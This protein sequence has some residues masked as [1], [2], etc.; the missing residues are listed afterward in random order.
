MCVIT[1]TGAMVV[2]G[3]ARTADRIRSRLDIA[4][5]CFPTAVHPALTPARGFDLERSW[6]EEAL[7]PCAASRA[8]RIALSRSIGRWSGRLV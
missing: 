7:S 4:E 3:S 5:T 2:A 6:T 8:P 1:I